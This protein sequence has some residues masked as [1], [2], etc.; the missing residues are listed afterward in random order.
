MIAYVGHRRSITG[1]RLSPLSH[2]CSHIG[3]H[4]GVLLRDGDSSSRFAAPIIGG[5]CCS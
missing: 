5:M 2:H 3:R 4:R 1:S